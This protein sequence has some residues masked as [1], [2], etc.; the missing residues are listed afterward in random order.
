MARIKPG[1]PTV[2]EI[3]EGE[4]EYRY[5]HG[6][7]LVLYTRYSNQIYSTKMHAASTPP[8]MDKKLEMAIGDRIGASTEGDEFI[9]ADGTVQFTGNQSHGG[10]DIVSVN[11]LDVDGDIDVD[12]TANLDN[13]DIDGTLD[14]DGATTLDQT[15]IN[16]TDGDFSVT[17]PNDISFVTTGTSMDTGIVLNSSLNFNMDVTRG[18]DWNTDAVD[19]D[20]SGAFDLTSVDDITIE[21]SGAATAKTILLF[22]DNNHA[23]A[24]RGIHLKVD[25]QNTAS[26][27]NSILIEC[28]NRAAKG[29]GIGVDIASEDGI[30]IRAEDA[31]SG[32]DSYVQ[33]RATGCVDI[34][35][36]T[37]SL[38]PSST[39]MRTRIH[40]VFE[41]SN[42]FRIDSTVPI[43]M[44][45]G[46]ILGSSATEV[47]TKFEAIDTLKLMRAMTFKTS[48]SVARTASHTILS[49][50]DDDNADGT[51]WLITI[52]W[53][54]AAADVNSQL[55]MCSAVGSADNTLISV[56]IS[57][58]L[59]STAG[60]AAGTL[61]WTNSA[62]IVWTNGHDAASGSTAVMKASA[63]RIQSGT[64]DF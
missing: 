55:W 36:G 46:T 14:V 48:G 12:G 34:G 64:L 9:R 50:T 30:L 2:K 53:K 43:V 33:I 22:N 63:L 6:T 59:E 19:W 7:G 49:A 21:T 10:H 41:T 13:T 37:T 1:V 16:T 56:K 60:T 54:H 45:R 3:R 42:L 18:C 57:E 5:I 35:G 24:F 28:A 58:N 29:G 61:L 11:D 51:S 47:Y 38:T 20:N 25:S 23:S 52:V 44:D 31:D 32:D 27:Q 26:S 39:T 15:T 17:G 8:V 62:G 40:G 4:S